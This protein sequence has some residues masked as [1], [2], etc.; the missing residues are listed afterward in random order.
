MKKCDECG[1]DICPGPG[2]TV[3][4]WERDTWTF[5]SVECRTKWIDHCKR[6]S[7]PCRKGE[8]PPQT[9]H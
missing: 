2:I 1:H 9:D 6:C 8:D 7:I 4:T 3:V 5:C